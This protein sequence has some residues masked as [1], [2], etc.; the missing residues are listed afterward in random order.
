MFCERCL[1]VS[2]DLRMISKRLLGVLGVSV[3]HVQ[4]GASTCT[5]WEVGKREVCFLTPFLEQE[6]RQENSIGTRRVE[7]RVLG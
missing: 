6:E 2:G 3:L 7:G 1:G 5:R 4:F